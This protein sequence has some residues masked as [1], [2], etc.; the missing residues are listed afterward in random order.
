MRTVGPPSRMASTIA[1]IEPMVMC[2]KSGARSGTASVV[3]CSAKRAA[4]KRA[5]VLPGPDAK[6]C[7]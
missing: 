7:R 3:P 1:S 4:M 2:V 6:P 5:F